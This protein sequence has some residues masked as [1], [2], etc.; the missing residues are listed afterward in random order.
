M[1][2]QDLMPRRVQAVG[3]RRADARADPCDCIARF[4]NPRR[5]H[6]NLGDFGPMVSEAAALLARPAVLGKRD[7]DHLLPLLI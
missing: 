4:C 1:P 7:V 5:R 2:H 3:C 6:S